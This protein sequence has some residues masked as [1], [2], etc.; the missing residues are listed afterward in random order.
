MAVRIGERN[1]IDFNIIGVVVLVGLGRVA[2]GVFHH[3]GRSFEWLTRENGTR[4]RGG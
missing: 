4:K 3:Q 2:L 1:G